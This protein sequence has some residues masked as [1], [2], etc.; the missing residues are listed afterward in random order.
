MAEVEFTSGRAMFAEPDSLTW[1]VFSL[2]SLTGN[3]LWIFHSF[4][5]LLALVMVVV[6]MLSHTFVIVIPSSISGGND[7]EGLKDF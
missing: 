5:N 4:D 1:L 3:W 6:V 2:C 7:E